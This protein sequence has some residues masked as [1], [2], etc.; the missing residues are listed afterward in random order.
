M[1]VIHLQVLRA[2]NESAHSL[3]RAKVVRKPDLRIVTCGTH[4]PWGRSREGTGELKWEDVG[5]AQEEYVQIVGHMCCQFCA[6]PG[7][8]M[9]K[10]RNLLAVYW[11][12][13]PV[14]MILSGK[15]R[16]YI[17]HTIWEAFL[18]SSFHYR[19][20]SCHRF[21]QK[22]LLDAPSVHD[23]QLSRSGIALPLTFPLVCFFPVFLQ[24]P[25]M[26]WTCD[27]WRSDQLWV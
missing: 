20:I 11:L 8:V 17:L 21:L 15:A 12:T 10:D 13:L 23:L 6:F 19:R 2:V 1:A 7:Q 3:G 26:P 18:L 4:Q 9:P 25:L 16:H 5:E 22:S 27:V 24:F 14:V